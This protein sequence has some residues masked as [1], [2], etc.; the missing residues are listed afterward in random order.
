MPSRK[1]VELAAQVGHPE[2]VDHV[3]GR[4]PQL[5]ALADGDVQL[6]GHRDPGISVGR[7]PRELEPDDVDHQAVAFPR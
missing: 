5:D 1:G 3:G 4:Q 2:A 7:L 6:V